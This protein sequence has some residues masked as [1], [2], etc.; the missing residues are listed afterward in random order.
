M[1]GTISSENGL[2]PPRCSADFSQSRGYTSIYIFSGSLD[3]LPLR[4]G[5]AVFSCT[6]CMLGR[7][8]FLVSPAAATT[9]AAAAP[10]PP[11]LLSPLPSPL[12]SSLSLPTSL[13]IYPS[14][15]SLPARRLPPSLSVSL[16]PSLPPSLPSSV[17]L[18]YTQQDAQ[19]HQAVRETAGLKQWDGE[20]G[21][22]G[23]V[24]TEREQNESVRL[25]QAGNERR[26]E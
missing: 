10:P 1:R 5:G 3:F 19:T 6:R 24:G 12:L 15:S 2:S 8:A 22:E 25:E 4:T 21:G 16:S 18:G 13:S 26:R 7:A 9:A 17:S 14:P 20:G 11:P 23:G